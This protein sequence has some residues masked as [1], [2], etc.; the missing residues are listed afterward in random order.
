[1]HKRD[2][3]VEMIKVV[4]EIIE[5]HSLVR[6]DIFDLK[7]AIRDGSSLLYDLLPSYLCINMG[8][9]GLATSNNIKNCTLISKQGRQI[10]GVDFVINLMRSTI[11]P[12]C[13]IVVI[14]N[15]E[16]GEEYCLELDE[17]DVMQITEGD[18]GLLED[19]DPLDLNGMIIDNLELIERD[20]VKFLTCTNKVFF[21]QLWHGIMTSKL[22][23]TS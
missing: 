6:H 20:G 3:P 18:R 22:S 2:V 9:S 12:Y 15:L 7:T 14:L 19:A 17:K 10:N 13:F 16:T 21:N 5:D 4:I 11:N 8:H 23:H 1:M